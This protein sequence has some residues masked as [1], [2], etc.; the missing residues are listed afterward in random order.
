LEANANGSHAA[1][2]A[3]TQLAAYALDDV[4]SD[5]FSIK[6][7][8]NH[9]NK[10]NKNITITYER[11]ADGNDA[12]PARHARNSGATTASNTG[13]NAAARCSGGTNDDSNVV[14]NYTHTRNVV[15]TPSNTQ[16]SLSSNATFALLSNH[17]RRLPRSVVQWRVSLRS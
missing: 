5:V 15:V 14:I 11:A 10:N 2:M 17:R 7:H 1:A 3:S 16:F 9:S 13:S 6:I 8:M 12:A 4:T